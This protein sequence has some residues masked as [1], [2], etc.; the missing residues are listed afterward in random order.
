M[1]KR[2]LHGKRY[3]RS[4]ASVQV[5]R[6]RKRLRKW[7][8]AFSKLHPLAKN[9]I[10]AVRNASEG[11]AK[12]ARVISSLAVELHNVRVKQLI[13]GGDTPEA[14]RIIL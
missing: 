3:L 6:N 7:N 11:L 8:R 14:Q 2:T 9:F 12:F 13:D 1:P 5:G 4:R 10:N